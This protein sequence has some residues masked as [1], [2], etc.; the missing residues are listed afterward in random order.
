[1]KT[2]TEKYSEKKTLWDKGLWKA[3]VKI[4]ARYCKAVYS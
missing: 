2:S 1:M 3:V 4:H